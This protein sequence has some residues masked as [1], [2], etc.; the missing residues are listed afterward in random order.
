MTLFDVFFSYLLPSKYKLPNCP[1]SH[2]LCLFVCHTRIQIYN[3]RFIKHS[4]HDCLTSALTFLVIVLAAETDRVSWFSG[5]VKCSSGSHQYIQKAFR[6]RSQSCEK[7]LFGMNGLGFVQSL[8]T[9][10]ACIYVHCKSS[11]LCSS[12]HSSLIRGVSDG[13]DTYFTTGSESLWQEE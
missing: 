7:Q 9:L 6:Y 3:N 2:T 4:S 10:S 8:P 11:P 12:L 1:K 13:S 5:G